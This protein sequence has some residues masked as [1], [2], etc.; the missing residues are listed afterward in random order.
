MEKILA[1]DKEAKIQ[2]KKSIQDSS[3]ANL[4]IANG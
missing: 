3:D 2:P 1:D 4:N